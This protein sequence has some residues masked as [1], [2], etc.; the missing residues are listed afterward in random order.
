ME[1]VG[2]FLDIESDQGMNLSMSLV[3]AV[4]SSSSSM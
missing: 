3:V 4:G 1:G 2:Q